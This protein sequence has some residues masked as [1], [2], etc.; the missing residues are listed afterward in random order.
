MDCKLVDPFIDP[1]CQAL[2]ARGSIHAE[3]FALFS[4]CSVLPRD[5]EISGSGAGIAV[6]HGTLDADGEDMLESAQR[7]SDAGLAAQSASNAFLP[8]HLLQFL[9]THAHVDL[10]V[11]WELPEILEDSQ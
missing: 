3:A 11:W 5:S 10:A 6:V 1:S 9:G 2:L 4:L 7:K 8:G